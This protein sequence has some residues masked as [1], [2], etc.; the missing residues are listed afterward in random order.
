MTNVGF[1]AIFAVGLLSAT[2]ALG[3]MVA[4]QPSPKTRVPWAT[5]RLTG[6]P[7]EPPAYR[8]ERVYPHLKFQEPASIARVPGTN[9]L[10]I[11][12]LRG[13][14]LTFPDDP[15]VAKADLFLDV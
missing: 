11:A 13:Q 12:E 4:A 9:R 10:L 8:T 7:D 5:S 6:S 15:N 2:T 14:L 1:R 3:L